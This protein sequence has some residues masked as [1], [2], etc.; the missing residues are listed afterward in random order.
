MSRPLLLAATSNPHKLRELRRLLPAAD[1]VGFA[2]AQAIGSDP[3]TWDVPPSELE[4]TGETFLDNAVLKAVHAS[5]RCDLP[6]IADDSGLCIDALGGRPGVRSAR[7]GGPGLDDEQRW[8]LV[9][10]E[11]RGVPALRRQAAYRAVVAL[12][13]RGRVL[14]LH[15]GAC[16]GLI[17]DAPRGSGGFGYDPVF[18]VESLGKTMA[19]LTPDEKDAL[20]HRARAMAGLRQALEDGILEQG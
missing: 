7:H 12:A 10:E 18:L 13:R 6:V 1:V 8:R 11:M 9:L 2:D 4:E 5:L 16:S 15:E 14:S 20:S 19:E 17:L 3:A